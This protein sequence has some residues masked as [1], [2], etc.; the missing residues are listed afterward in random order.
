MQP[1]SMWYRAHNGTQYIHTLRE[2]PIEILLTN[3]SV[4]TLQRLVSLLS[5]IKLAMLLYNFSRTFRIKSTKSENV[6]LKINDYS[7]QKYYS[8]TIFHRQRE[9]ERTVLVECKCTC[10]TPIVQ[11][12]MFA[13]KTKIKTLNV[14]ITVIDEATHKSAVV[15]E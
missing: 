12:I 15:H 4:M 5:S 8:R 7:K 14:F 13:I 2:W 6:Q 11:F 10:H 9:R 3:R 1:V